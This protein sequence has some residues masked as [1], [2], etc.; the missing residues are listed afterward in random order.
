VNFS[1]GF[2]FNR[3][4]PGS[5]DPAAR[6]YRLEGGCGFSMIERYALPKMSSIWSL[7][8]KYRTWLTV[9]LLACEAMVELGKVPAPAL[10]KIKRTASIDSKRIEELEV[11]VKHDVIAF[12]TSITEQVGDEGRFLHMGMTSSDV[13]DTA[14]AIQMTQAADLLIDDLKALLRVLKE[15]A[16]QYKETV[17]IGRS[18]GIHAEPITF[19]LKMAL[20][21][22]ETRRNL[23]RMV[24][25]RETASYGKISG[26]VGTFAHLPPFVEEF[27][28]SRSGLTPEPVSNQ[29]VQ[30]D[31]H[32][33]Y[34]VTL[35]IVAAS[36]EK[37]STEIRH[38]QRSE[39]LEAE[40]YF[41]EGQKGSSAMP[42]KRNPIGCENLCGLARVV[43]ANA[44]AALE[45]VPLWHE[46]DIS[47]SSV[48]RIILPDSTIL[49]DFMLNRF[50]GIV[51]RLLVYPERM[52]KNLELSRGTIYSQKLLLLLIEQGMRREL[53]YELI[54]RLAMKTYQEGGSFLDRVRAD[55]EVSSRLSRREIEA[56]FDPKSFLLHLDT[57]Y[58]RVFSSPPA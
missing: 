6:G 48:E 46:R 45:D 26:A 25:A 39:V 15:K 9:E 54:Q 23:A 56:C 41:D 10:E 29:I 24:S 42:H 28:C 57:I 18:H 30:R 52:I 43:R 8:N 55:P 12:L 21:Y 11:K 31:R 38:L 50:T 37:F 1:S 58:K 51:S 35:A 3:G 13:L 14:L 16:D 17:M 2:I 34:L 7:D 53:A 27:V 49:L 47:H 20:W 32:A 19:G 44:L 4:R 36:I 33:Q 22:E 40:E 5:T